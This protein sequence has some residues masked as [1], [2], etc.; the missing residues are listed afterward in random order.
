[1]IRQYTDIFG[2]TQQ[3]IRSVSIIVLLGARL[4]LPAMLDRRRGAAVARASRS[5]RVLERMKVV[6]VGHVAFP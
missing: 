4:R 3:N 1:L 2:S 6:V 5:L